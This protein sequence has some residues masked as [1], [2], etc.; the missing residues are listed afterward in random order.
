MRYL[1]ER[2]A[3]DSARPLLVSNNIIK[4]VNSDYLLSFFHNESIASRH[5]AYTML[6]VIGAALLGFSIFLVFNEKKIRFYS[7][8]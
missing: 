2:F 4:D 1:N 7:L 5:W 3:D 6:I 8:F